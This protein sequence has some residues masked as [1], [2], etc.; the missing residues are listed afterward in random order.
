MREHVFFGIGVIVEGEDDLVT[1][2]APPTNAEGCRSFG[3]PG[4][5]DESRAVMI[6]ARMLTKTARWLTLTTGFHP[7]QRAPGYDRS[8]PT[9]GTDCRMA[10]QQRSAAALQSGNTLWKIC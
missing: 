3:G 8:S 7:I 6:P 2:P 4:R 5:A 9:G 10:T 1:K